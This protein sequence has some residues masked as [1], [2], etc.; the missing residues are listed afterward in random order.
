MTRSSYP[1][2]GAKLVLAAAFSVCAVASQAA[3]FYVVVPIKGK[4]AAAVPAAPINVSLQSATLPAGKVG[5]AYS[6]D[7]AQHILVTGDPALDLSQAQLTATGLPAG[8]SLSAAGL[9]TG[10]PTVKTSG[11]SFEVSAAYKS[12]TGAQTYTVQV[13]DVGFEAL[14]LSSASSSTCAVTPAGAVLCWGYNSTGQL[15]DG[16]LINR[17]LPTAIPSLVSGATAVASGGSHSC[18]IVSGAVS[19]WGND[20]Y[21]QLG[22]GAAFSTLTPTPVQG[23]TGLQVVALSAGLGHTCAIVTGGSAY[24]W[25]VAGSTSRLG[26][27]TTSDRPTAARV[28]LA[29][30]DVA[31]KLATTQVSSCALL[32]DGSVKCWGTNYSSTP[33]AVPGL[34]NIVD[35]A[36]SPTSGSTPYTCAVS[37]DGRVFCWTSSAGIVEVPGI[38]GASQVVLGNNYTC[39]VTTGGVKCWATSGSATAASL[40]TIAGVTSPVQVSAGSSFVC[41]RQQ[42]N[43]VRC[44]GTGTSGQLGQGSM[45]SAPVGTPVQVLE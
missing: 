10:S 41:V 36:G 31:V 25:G 5:R 22:N 21:G 3:D 27:G 20:T 11:T 37:S 7:F 38:S 9:L 18:A 23:L 19:C 8:L 13:R 40:F 35:I 32:A 29:V 24:C 43:L 2:F 42:D 30:G 6:Y 1:A 39:A 17:S 34:A 12:K 28:S 15:G 26:D 16:T 4:T 33:M 14:T 44:G 45:T